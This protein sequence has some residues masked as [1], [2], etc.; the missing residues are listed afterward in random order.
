MSAARGA[1]QRLPLADLTRRLRSLDGL[2]VEALR[3]EWRRL[4]RVPAPPC[5]SRDLLLRGISYRLQ[6]LALGGLPPATQRRLSTPSAPGS[7]VTP[8]RTRAP[9]PARVKPGSTLVRAWHGETHTV[10]VGED[11]FE[12]Q[13][14]RYA[15]L[16]QIAREITGAHWS[17]PRFFGLR[18]EPR[19]I[20]GDDVTAASAT[21]TATAPA[22]PTATAPKTRIREERLDA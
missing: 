1:G 9:P 3:A 6:E 16:S 8:A 19:A 20:A 11:G 18:R 14:R 7:G 17:G 13:G 21:A 5:Y 22:V 2:P 12:H 15:S 10:L 4:Y